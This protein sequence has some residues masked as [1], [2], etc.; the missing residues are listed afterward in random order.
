M[1]TPRSRPDARTHI[2]LRNLPH[3][4]AAADAGSLHRAAQHLGIAQSALSRRIADVEAE[5]GAP[6]FHREPHGVRPT[7]AGGDLVG[8]ADRLLRDLARSIRHFELRA[9]DAR[10]TLRIGFNS[11]AMMFAATTRALS[12]FRKTHPN[13]DLQLDAMLSEAQYSALSEG[14]IDVGIGYLLSPELPFATRVITGDRMILALPTDHA[15]CAQPQISVADLHG[16]AFIGM[17]QETSGLLARMVTA[18]LDATG[19]GVR[20]TMR[21]GS[22]EATLNLVAAGLGLAFVNQ[23]QSGRCPPNVVLREIAD[24]DFPVP[25]GLL[26]NAQAAVPLVD[27][28]LQAV[29]DHHAGVMPKSDTPVGKGCLRLPRLSIV[30]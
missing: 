1:N 29:T 26:W 14:R 17:Q 19:V 24:F 7:T 10:Q 3:I 20:T 16:A 21:A 22:S 15:L 5:L 30:G 25:V 2:I 23:S 8:D 12:A 13:A 18:R 11:A 9:A 4:V 27:D 28:F 6:V